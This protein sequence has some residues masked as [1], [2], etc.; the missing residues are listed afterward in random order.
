MHCSVFAA[1]Q[2]RAFLTNEICTLFV[3]GIFLVQKGHGMVSNLRFAG[4][5]IASLLQSEHFI[6]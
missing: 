1:P 5:R 2:T 3:F 6:G 4:T